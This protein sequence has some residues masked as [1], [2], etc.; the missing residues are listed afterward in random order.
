MSE[1]TALVEE[2]REITSAGH[3]VTVACDDD[4][5]MAGDFLGELKEKEKAA[6]AFFEPMVKATHKAHKEVKARENEVVQ[7]LVAAKKL[8]GAVMGRYQVQVEAGLERE[9]IQLQKE[10]DEAALVEAA[11]LEKIAEQEKAA[12][13]EEASRLAGEGKPEEATRMEEAAR[14]EE[15]AWLKLSDKALEN[16]P[17]VMPTTV[18]KVEAT[19]VRTFWKYEIVD[20]PKIPREYMCV[21]ERLIGA[22]VRTKKGSTSIPG[23]RVYS[24]TRVV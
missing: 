16:A 18:P 15:A 6:R 3:N 22:T 14:L 12:R 10:T 20:E 13:M 24:D 7:P 8:V 11:R 9:R 2:I 17:V 1:E 21:D 23:V 19:S 5:E 4:Y